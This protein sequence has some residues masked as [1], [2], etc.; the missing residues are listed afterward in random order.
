M[1]PLQHPILKQTKI[2]IMFL[3]LT[4]GKTCKQLGKCDGW[5]GSGIH[6][7]SPQENHTKVRLRIPFAGA[8]AMD[9]ALG[10]VLP[11]D[12]G[13]S[14]FSLARISAF[15]KSTRS[16]AILVTSSTSMR[17]R[18]YESLTKRIK[19]D[20]DCWVHKHIDCC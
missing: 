1:P 16:L 20:I 8:S 12:L 14:D 17:V 13:F 5:L 11:A 15:A 19:Q 18:F 3:V 2:K 4:H 9:L 7:E 6:E 10:L